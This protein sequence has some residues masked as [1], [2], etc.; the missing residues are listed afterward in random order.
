MVTAIAQ[1]VFGMIVLVALLV[2]YRIAQKFL[3]S[4]VIKTIQP[5]EIPLKREIYCDAEIYRIIIRLKYELNAAK[6][7]IGRFH[8]G[9]VFVNGLRMKKFTITHETVSSGK[10]NS[11][12]MMD[13]FVGTMNSRYCM[14]FEALMVQELFCT[15]DMS[16]CIDLNFRADMES[17]GF[18]AVYLFLLK[19]RSGM[20]EGFIGVGFREST[21]LSSEQRDVVREA[22]DRIID[23]M[24]LKDMP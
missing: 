3:N 2:L 23:L 11:C 17:F 8:D 6:T 21:V 16:D 7:F 1:I 24:N 13:T 10:N 12:P 19:Q 5:L 4:P 15:S 18:Q 22:G 20:E 14:A 9:G